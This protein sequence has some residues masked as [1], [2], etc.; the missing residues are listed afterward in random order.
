VQI[1]VIEAEKMADLV[2]HGFAD[3][4]AQLGLR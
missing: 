3:P 4:L 2:Q 1:L